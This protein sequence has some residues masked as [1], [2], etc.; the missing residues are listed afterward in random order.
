[1][2]DKTCIERVFWSLQMNVVRY[3]YDSQFKP[4]LNI[5]K[6]QEHVHQWLQMSNKGEE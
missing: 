6:S 4:S 1:M 3:G 2:V 5:P